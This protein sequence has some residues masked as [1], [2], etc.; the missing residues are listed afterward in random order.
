M[1]S[2]S[3]KTS[4][5]KGLASWRSGFANTTDTDWAEQLRIL[6][7]TADL[8]S[9]ELSLEEITQAIY[10]NVNDLFDAYQFAVGLYDEQEGLITYRGMIENG[11]R[12]PDFS[13]DAKDQH[14]LASWCIRNETE[15]FMN[16]FDKE[17][18]QYLGHKPIPI[19]G[20]DPKAALYVPLK[21][22]NKVVGLI[23]VRTIH[24]N[25]YQPHHLHILR[26]V[27]NFIVRTLALAR[28]SSS[29]HQKGG[30]QKQW[31]WCNTSELTPS[32]RRTL[33]SLTDRE[34]EV[35]LLLVTGLP[36]KVIA[37][38]LFVSAATIKTH[39]LNIY[40]KMEVSNRTSAIIKAMEL[41][42]IQ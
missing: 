16:D 21:L 40:Q 13:F 14:R 11:K 33:S 7:N 38:K 30:V 25:V 1:S 17:Y 39:T 19:V 35:L 26:T 18:K 8:I 3:K 29:S 15:I 32:S 42:W 22:N 24:K 9:P 34:R 4:F 2:S 37:E 20:S 28:I 6:N 27:G 5:T 23:T 31:H 41:G 12:M 10:A 36:N